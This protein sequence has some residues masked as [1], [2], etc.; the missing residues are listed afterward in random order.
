MVVLAGR[1][2]GHK[3]EARALRPAPPALAGA[4]ACAEALARELTFPADGAA[5]KG[6]GA[7]RAR[8][9]QRASRRRSAH[10]Q[11]WRRHRP[12][13][14]D[15]H[16]ALSQKS[17]KSR[18]QDDRVKRVRTFTTP[19]QA[20]NWPL[21]RVVSKTVGRRKAARGFDPTPSAAS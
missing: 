1:L 19:A 3:N 8:T 5:R 12:V 14:S 2:T 17:D 20:H 16:V 7:C 10:P 6:L 13:H 9:P 4:A 11:C 21:Q 15:A 18:S